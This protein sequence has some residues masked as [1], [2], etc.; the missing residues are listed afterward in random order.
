MQKLPRIV[1]ALTAA[2]VLV[3]AE[4]AAQPGSISNGRVETIAATHG[5][6]VAVRDL[7]SRTS[8]AFWLGYA[9]PIL[10]G[11]RGSCCSWSDEA[12]RGDT[13]RDAEATTRLIATA[14]A[15][16]SGRVRGDA[17]F[18]LAQRAGARIASTIADAIA[19]DPETEV[20]KRAVFALSQLPKDEGVPL[21]IQIA[22]TNRNPEV[23]KQAMF[24]LGQ[25]KDQRAIAFFEEILKVK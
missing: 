11:R 12:G 14:R 5:L 2:L 7:S 24:W 25:S 19:N 16:A 4:A 10:E 9:V 21:L 15:H 23:R 17:L 3:R 20:K 6:A 8:E 18:W 22:R 13:C 1:C